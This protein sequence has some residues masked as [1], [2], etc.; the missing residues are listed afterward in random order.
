MADEHDSNRE[1]EELKLLYQITVD[2]IKYAKRLLW[3]IGYSILLGYSAIIGFRGFINIQHIAPCF[4]QKLIYI[5][6]ILFLAIFIN[7]LGIYQLMEIQKTLSVYRM[8]LTAIKLSLGDK[9]QKIIEVS[10]E[11][12]GDAEN[13]Y[14]YNR[15]GSWILQFIILFAVGI[16]FVGIVSPSYFNI[17]WFVALLSGWEKRI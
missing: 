2:D 1:F 3:T 8:R 16:Y 5:M 13:Y 17:F 15:Y 11:F 9:F 6:S 12:K 4:T 14:S 7:I 10:N